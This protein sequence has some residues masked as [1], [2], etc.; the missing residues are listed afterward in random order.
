[1]RAAAPA[2][3]AFLA[4]LRA[5][6][7]APVLMADCYTFTLR[8]GS[9]G[10]G[11]VIAVTNADVPVTLNGT[12]FR[13]DSLLVDGLQYRCATGLDVDRQRITIAARPS[14]TINGVPFLASL[15]TGLLDGCEVQ[16]DRAYLRDWSAPPVGSVTLFKGRVSSVDAVGRTSAEITVASEL[17][18]LDVDVPRNLYQPACNHVLY[19]SG[20][21]L[22]KSAYGTAGQAGAGATPT[23]LPWSAATPAF[24]QGT[25]SFSGGANAGTSANIKAA[26]AGMLTLSAP[27]AG[28][29][30]AGDGFTAYLGC[31]HTLATCRGRFGNGGNFRGF[32]FV[33]A[34]ETAY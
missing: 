32:P 16:R 21:G 15:R 30:A 2:L 29:P 9:S 19:D 26:A 7:D 11:A 4:A 28:A 31:D 18:L 12:V 24:A 5:Q 34:P 14:D 33:P 13:A 23:L 1:M 25:V 8:Q 17:V 10:L 20:C 27:L 6:R 22:V 3:A